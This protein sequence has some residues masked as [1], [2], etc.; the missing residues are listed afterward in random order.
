MKFFRATTKLLSFLIATLFVYTLIMLCFFGAILGINYEK[1]RGY[2]LRFWGKICCKIIGIELQVIN[3]PPKP[4]FLLVSN[5]LSYIDVFVLF[6]QLRCLFVAKSDVKSW[7]LMGFIIRTCG[8]LFIDRNRK[9]DVTRVNELI[10][11]NINQ[12]QGIILF[13]EGTTSPGMDILPFRTSLLQYPAE[14][15]FPVSYVSISYETSDEEI[16]AYQSVCWWD[17]TPFFV[18]FFELLKMKEIHAKLNFGKETITEND[19]KVLAEKL[20]QVVK[21]EFVPVITKPNFK[22]KHG[23]FRSVFAV[24]N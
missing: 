3:V 16:P 7:P 6:S 10:S 2:L 9:R 17:E 12:N 8:I 15:N 5:H 24:K 23:E 11:K 14:K 1:I 4:P 13:P 21:E 18:H 20:Q 19:R 22:E